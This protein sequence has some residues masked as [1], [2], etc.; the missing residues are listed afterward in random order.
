M[1][2]IAAAVSEIDRMRR[3]DQERRQEHD[4]LRVAI[5]A[6]DLAIDGLERLNLT[7]C[8]RL[9]AGT[10]IQI[11]LAL[12]PVPAE[13][14]PEMQPRDSI[15][16]LMDELYRTQESLFM[17]KSGPEWQLLADS[18]LESPLQVEPD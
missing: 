1:H 11:A 10:E 12:R 18:E 4:R 8:S 2:G 3:L 16:R 17:E 9:P 14:R 7:N 13:F 5:R 6:I 15:E